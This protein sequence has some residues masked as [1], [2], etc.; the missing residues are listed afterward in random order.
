MAD[1]IIRAALHEEN[2]N[3]WVWFCGPALKT[4]QSRR[5]VRFCR[6]GYHR[7][8]YTEVRKIDCNFLGRY[9]DDDTKSWGIKVDPKLNTIVMAEWYRV[10]LAIRDTTQANNKTG[11]ITLHVKEIRWW[12]YKSLRFACHHPDPAVRLGTRLGVLGVWLG[13]LALAD[14][15]LKVYEH[16]DDKY[17][18]L[19]YL[20]NILRISG[21][22]EY[23]HAWAMMIV[24]LLF[25]AAGVWACWGRPE[26]RS[27]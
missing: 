6:P 3:G 26:P 1:Y 15:A 7:G 10:A 4:L 16:F 2:N 11:T 14:P 9:N 18:R 25:A 8:V 13:V 27:R 17:R 23:L 22:T 19:E 5:I 20:K 24:A 12:G 21:P